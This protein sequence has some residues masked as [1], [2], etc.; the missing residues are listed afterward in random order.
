MAADGGGPF[1][2]PARIPGIVRFGGE[3]AQR[4]YR[5]NRFLVHIARPDNRATFLADEEAQMRAWQL[6]AAEADLVRRRD[7]NGLLHAGVNVYAIAKSGYVFGDTLI[8][9]GKRMRS[10]AEP[11]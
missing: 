9:I 11:A 3:H 2:P 7:Y 6:T 5:L 10:G 8:D 1:G 4:G